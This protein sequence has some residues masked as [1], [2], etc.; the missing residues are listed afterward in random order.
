MLAHSFSS[1]DASLQ[2]LPV[3]NPRPRIESVE[4][5]PGQQAH[6]IDDVAEPEALVDLAVQH[7]A[8]LSACGLR[9][10]GR[11]MVDAA[12]LRWPAADDF[13]R[14]HIRRLLAD[15]ARWR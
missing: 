1:I 11:R 4:I 13:F 7:R 10:P 14:I 15:G 3:F 9:P 12:R 2:H 6:V 5:A 8:C